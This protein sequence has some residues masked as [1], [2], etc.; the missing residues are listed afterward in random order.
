MSFLVPGLLFGLLLAAAPIIIHILNRRRFIRVDWGPMEFLKKTLRSNRKRLRIEQWLLLAL[1]T[2]AVALLILA[3]AR[4]MGQGLNLAGMLKLQSRASRVV[5]IDDSLSMGHRRAGVSALDRAEA[6]AARILQAIGPQDSITLIRTSNPAQPLVRDAQLTEEQL[7]NLVSQLE[8]GA[9]TGVAN[10]WR[11]TFDAI[12]LHLKGAT[13]P[14]RDVLIVTDLRQAGWTTDLAE[15][16]DR[17]AKEDITLRLFDVG[18]DSV[19]N[20]TLVA[21]ERQQPVVLTNIPA[22]FTA[23]IENRGAETLQSAH[24]T[25]SLDGVEQQLE[26]PAVE[27]GQQVELP[28]MLTFDQPGQHRVTV[29]LPEDDL[30]E[31]NVRH[32]SVDVRREVAVTLVDGEPGIEPFESETDYLSVAL[33]AGNTQWRTD[34]VIASDWAAQPLGAPDVLVLANV[35]Q[36]SVERV[37]ALEEMV[38][39]GMGVLIFPGNQVDLSLWNERLYRDGEGMLPVRLNRPRTSESE[40]LFIEAVDDSS[41][42]MMGRLKSQV[43][44]RIRP[45][46]ILDVTLPTGRDD[47]VQVLASWDDEQR[48]PAL[49]SKQ[50]GK[51]RVFLWTVSADRDWSD[52]PIETSFVLAMRQSAEGVAAQ[53]LRWE[54]LTAGQPIVWPFELGLAPAVANVT[55]PDVE[56]SKVVAVETAVSG[57]PQVRWEQTSQPGHYRVDW[58]GMGGN[59]KDRWFAI[60]PDTRDSDLTRLPETTLSSTLGKLIPQLERVEGET[61]DIASAGTEYWRPLMKLLLLLLIGETLLAAWIDRVR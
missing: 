4:P 11:S 55:P 13:F 35:D 15:V 59:S 12:D 29:S 33:T 27:S 53:V 25:L 14:I 3:V 41:L 45:K 36:L 6:V 42:A 40:G 56:E 32:L 8:G 2:L 17:W 22:R 1:R 57:P 37:A 43:L 58:E 10:H 50:F 48:A 18:V 34:R 19:G 9:V 24:V 5:V 7:A 44:G 54:N 46:Q 47:G 26:L 21:L 51:G 23:S 39:A 28:L 49:V 31:D 38:R 61:L 30:L 16:G 20:R 52:W 60:S